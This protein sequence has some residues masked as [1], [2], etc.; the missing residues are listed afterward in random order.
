MRGKPV[1]KFF[2]KCHVIR[3]ETKVEDVRCTFKFCTVQLRHNMRRS[4]DSVASNYCIVIA[5]KILVKRFPGTVELIPES[6]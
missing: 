3:Y 1:P 6:F 2:I 5:D 4:L